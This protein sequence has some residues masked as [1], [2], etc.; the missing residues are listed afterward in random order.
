MDLF[1]SHCCSHYLGLNMINIM[2]L[3][4]QSS[5]IKCSMY[6]DGEEHIH[7]GTL[8]VQ[9]QH[10][11]GNHK[12]LKSNQRR[13]CQTVSDYPEAKRTSTETNKETEPICTL[14]ATWESD[15]PS[16][17]THL[18]LI[19]LNPRASCFN[20]SKRSRDNQCRRSFVVS[21]QYPIV[22]LPPHSVR[23][24]SGSRLLDSSRVDY[25]AMTSK[26]YLQFVQRIEKLC[27]GGDGIN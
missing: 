27:G 20:C 2:I 22:L 10:S 26:D 13:W 16:Y 19:Y 17:G 9:T 6:M 12:F 7:F 3:I 23:L 15:H 24:V 18:L 5:C 21:C 11:D 1:S 25:T 4:Q 14:L 8:Q